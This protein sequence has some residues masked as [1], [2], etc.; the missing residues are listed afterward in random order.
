MAL[1][2]A[3]YVRLT[4][5]KQPLGGHHFHISA[6]FSLLLDLEALCWMTEIFVQLNT[7][8]ELRK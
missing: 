6:V 2:V 8:R 3:S 4:D 1:L 7:N 5:F